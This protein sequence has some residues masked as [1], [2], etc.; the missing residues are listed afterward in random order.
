MSYITVGK[1]NGTINIYY[2]DHGAGQP[3]VTIHGF[4]LNG[5][6][7]EKQVSG[8]PALPD[9]LKQGSYLGL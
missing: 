1:G 6:S 4:S 5:H 2:K 8:Q 9:F 7:W 3:V